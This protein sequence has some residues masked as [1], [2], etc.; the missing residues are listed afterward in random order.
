MSKMTDKKNT[1]ILKVIDGKGFNLWEVVCRNCG[2]YYQVGTSFLLSVKRPTEEE[3]MEE[4]DKVR[5]RDRFRSMMNS[6]K[7]ALREKNMEFVTDD[8]VWF[9]KC[10]LFNIT[11]EM[12][13][14]KEGKEAA[15]KL[16]LINEIK[17]LGYSI[18]WISA[19]WKKK[20]M[21]MIIKKEVPR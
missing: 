1:P 10:V 16:A 7:D 19:D 4:L 8:I 17:K 2:L 21:K 3:W 11:M 14:D 9:D 13:S 5:E 12:E 18:W 20:R 15:W 6:D